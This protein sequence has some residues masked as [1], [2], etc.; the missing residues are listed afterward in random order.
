MPEWASRVGTLE[1]Y[2]GLFL[3]FF[4][5]FKNGAGVPEWASRVATLEVYS[6]GVFW[7]P[8]CC[9][10]IGFHSGYSGGAFWERIGV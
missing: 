7:V 10:R 6:G 4:Q 1:G 2:S 3:L 9:A 5:Y 8:E